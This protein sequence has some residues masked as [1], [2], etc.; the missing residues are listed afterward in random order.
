LE[1]SKIRNDVPFADYGVTSIMGI[2]LMRTVSEALGIELDPIMLFEYTTV[3]ELADY[4][5]TTWPE[6]VTVPGPQAQVIVGRGTPASEANSEPRFIRKAQLA[7][8]GRTMEIRQDGSQRNGIHEPIAIIGMSG[9]FAE[10]ESLDEFWQSL[11][12]G[13]DLVKEVSRWSARDC[14][15]SE[16]AG[17]RYCSYGG[18]VSSIDRF[19]PSFFGISPLE[20]I[21]MDP[22]QRLFLEEA[23]KAL[24]DAGYGG[25]SVHEKECGVYVGCSS[26]F[27]DKLFVEDPPAHVF[28]GNA[29]A[30]LP[31]RIAYYLNL[32][33]P[34]I[35]VDT[36][37]SSSLVAIHLAC[38][39]LWSGEME[40]ALAGGVFLQ[41]SPGF[42]NVTNGW[43]GVQPGMKYEY[44]APVGTGRVEEWENQGWDKDD[45]IA[46]LNAYYANLILPAQ[47][48]YLRIP[49]AAEYW[50]ELDV[51]I[52][53][54]LSGATTPREALDDIYQ[55]WEKI[56]DRY[57]RESQKKLYAKS[58]EEL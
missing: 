43:T 36:A 44:F 31:A 42:F 57:G 26:S 18:F 6:K 30:A 41:A 2:N 1:V 40:M 39:A 54:V 35:A 16:S 58:Y 19:D 56:T 46:Y 7:E 45:A 52:S 20:A 34:A 12:E 27:Y 13:K 51:R 49:G 4:I 21:W 28:T 32:Q 9:R 8:A 24:E 55:A 53:S 33:G 29:M 38:Q 48:I 47:Q 23:W 11:K 50:H 25:K 14:V 5:C 37:S 10:A 17:E 3:D 22:Q 15:I